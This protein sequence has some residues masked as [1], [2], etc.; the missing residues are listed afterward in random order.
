MGAVLSIGLTS[1]KEDP[2]EVEDPVSSFQYSIS[3]SNSL[4]VAFTNYSQNADSYVWEFGDGETSTE[5]NPVHEYAAFG[6]YSVTLTAVNAE[7]TE[8]SYTQSFELKDPDAA[9]KLLTGD[10]SKTWQLYREGISMS[11]GE[12]ADNPANWWAGLENDAARPCVYKQTFTF[13]IDG[14]YVFDDAGLFWGEYGVWDADGDLHETCF[15]AVA[16]NMVNKEGADVSAWLS[17][18]YTFTYD[19][20]TGELVLNGDGAWIGIPKLDA[21]GERIAP[22]ASTTCNIAIEE[23]TGYDIMT[24][25]F[26]WGDGGYWKIVYASY[27]DPSTAPE[28]K[29]EAAAWGEDLT[30]VTPS[31]L[32]ITFASHD[33]ADLNGLDTITSG[34]TV[35]FGVDDPADASAAKVG[36][37]NRVA[38]VQWQELQMRTIPEANDIL[39]DN[40]T[41]VSVDIYV[42]SSNTFAEG[43]LQ[44]VMVVGFGDISETKGGWWTDNEEFSVATADI[45]EDEWKT[46][47]F[48][49]TADM[50]ARADLDMLYI[51]IGA[52]GHD[53]GGT[54]YIRNL[55]LE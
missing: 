42:P 45:P 43:G 15:E 24:V 11:L 17:G 29:E 4:E 12:S 26:D 25:S 51:G 8:H 28:I 5:E 3:E 47:T 50:K 39:F 32:G 54:F 31:S 13:G 19:P 22:A 35:D 55:V 44:K 27:D 21:A 18:T 10:V 52:G 46:Y 37:F 38:G 36:Q 14:S 16:A 23:M 2:V 7:E 53:A 9:L 20:A 49:L 1:C 48:D 33:A 6:S 40:L 34:S 41:T 30:D